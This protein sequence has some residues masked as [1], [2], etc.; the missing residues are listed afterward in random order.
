MSLTLWNGD[1]FDINL[2]ESENYSALHCHE[3]EEVT[4]Y[5]S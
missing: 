4:E 5:T 3:C 1:V 2:N